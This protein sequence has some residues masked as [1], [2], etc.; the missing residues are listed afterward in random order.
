[1]EKKMTII[2][3]DMDVPLMR[4]D[5]NDPDNVMWL[6]RNLSVRNSQHPEFEKVFRQVV[7]LKAKQMADHHWNNNFW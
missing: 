6:V 1:M 5:T 2:P 3:D 4:R 7:K